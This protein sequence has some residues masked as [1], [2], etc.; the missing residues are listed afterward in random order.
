[1]IKSELVQ[2][3]AA[4]NPHLY[5]RD[6]ENIVNAILGE[7]TNAMAQ[8]DRVELRG[9]GAF[10]VKH[11]PARTGR[12]PRT[13]AHVSVEQKSVP[14]FKTGKEMRERLNK[15]GAGVSGRFP[16]LAG[17]LLSWPG[18]ARPSMFLRGVTVVPQNRH[19]AR[20]RSAGRGHHRLRGGQPADGDGVVRSVLVDEPGLCGDAAAVRG[21]SSWC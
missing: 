12:N 8:G 13:G 15:T 5:Q 18:L 20:H 17:V 11:R 4:Q 3:I 19:L 2:R 14:F 7:I 21:S 9:F 10:S 16:A 6:V 1:M